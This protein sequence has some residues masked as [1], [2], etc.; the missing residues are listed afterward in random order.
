MRHLPTIITAAVIVLTACHKKSITPTPGIT[1]LACDV[2]H[3]RPSAIGYISG[4][5]TTWTS[6]TYDGDGR[7]KMEG[8]IQYIYDHDTLW[9]DFTDENYAA[10]AYRYYRP[11][12]IVD[13]VRTFSV[14]RTAPYDTVKIFDYSYT[15]DNLNEMTAVVIHRVEDG[16]PGVV[17][18][19]ST[20]YTWQDGNMVHS[21]NYADKTV[22][23]FEYIPNTNGH[24]LKGEP[25]RQANWIYNGNPVLSKNLVSRRIL[26]GTDTI[27][28][29]PHMNTYGTVNYINLTY[30]NAGGS[31]NYGTMIFKYECY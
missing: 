24:T 3:A 4:A 25:Y 18:T 14:T 26:N 28:Y 19:D 12:G 15:Y 31:L 17:T 9:Y 29:E 20:V 13:R 7:M 22:T 16:I 11:N 5:D 8:F 6:Y 30:H 2:Y 27:F 1:G 23:D 10:R 21:V